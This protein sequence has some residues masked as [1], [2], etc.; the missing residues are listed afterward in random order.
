[1][2]ILSYNIGQC[3]KCK[4]GVMQWL[5]RCTP[6]ASSRLVIEDAEQRITLTA[7]ITILYEICQ[8]TVI[9]EE[10]ILNADKFNLSYSLTNVITDINH[11]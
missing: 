6:G 7:F 2:N 4:C 10:T 9:T 11:N 8:S 1:M 5:D 3:S